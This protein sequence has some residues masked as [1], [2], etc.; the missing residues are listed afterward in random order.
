[1]TNLYSEE[2]EF[3]NHL[4]CW[5]P[6]FFIFSNIV[7]GLD[8]QKRNN[9]WLVQKRIITPTQSE[10]S[11]KVL[12]WRMILIKSTPHYDDQTSIFKVTQRISVQN[13]MERRVWDPNCSHPFQMAN[14]K[15]RNRSISKLLNKGQVRYWGLS[16][17]YNKGNTHAMDFLKS[18][19]S[20]VKISCKIS[21]I[22]WGFAWGIRLAIC[23]TFLWF[24]FFHLRV[25]AEGHKPES[26]PMKNWRLTEKIRLQHGFECKGG[27]IV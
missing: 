7:F 27:E 25:L 23:S 4:I 9:H 11:F 20:G 13:L 16:V 19:G 21:L 12:N 1:L 26:T 18:I 17:W 5:N 6:L 22:Y 24:L 2:S 10:I 3:V 14:S 15:C 8:V